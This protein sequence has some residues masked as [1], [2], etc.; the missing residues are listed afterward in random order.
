MSISHEVAP[1]WREFERGSTVVADAFV[2]PLL[3]RYVNSVRQSLDS[4]GLSLSVGNHE[5]QRRPRECHRWPRASRLTSFCPG[6]SGGIIGGKYFG[7]LAERT[8]R[9]HP[10]YGRH[11]L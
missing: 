10:G 8:E 6:Q 7:D 5:V 2:K 3:Q 9:D 11:E 4:L 1:I